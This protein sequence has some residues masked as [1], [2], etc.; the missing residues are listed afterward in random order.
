M[1]KENLNIFSGPNP[2]G[3]WTRPH[4]GLSSLVSS[5]LASFNCA[6]FKKQLYSTNTCELPETFI[7]S[8]LNPFDLGLI[9][10]V[11]LCSKSQSPTTPGNTHRQNV[12]ISSSPLSGDC[13]KKEKLTRPKLSPASYLSLKKI[14]SKH[15][16][17]LKR[18]TTWPITPHLLDSNCCWL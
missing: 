1:I 4:L 7:P 8:S 3:I 11:N 15:P 10:I 17:K 18:Y 14:V 13:I 5:L 12:L 6:K 16:C 9:W 2:T